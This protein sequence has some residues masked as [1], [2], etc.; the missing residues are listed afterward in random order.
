[1]GS[2]LSVLL[3]LVVLLISSLVGVRCVSLVVRVDVLLNLVMCRWFL[4]RLVRVRLTCLLWWDMV[5]RTALWCLLSSVLL[6]RAL[7]AMM[8][9]MCCLIKF[10]VSVG[11]LTRL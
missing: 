7:G 9:I 11:L 8:C 2:F 1:M 6:A 3:K 10:P 4:V 5:V